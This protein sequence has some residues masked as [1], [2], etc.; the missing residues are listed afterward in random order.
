MQLLY[1][2]QQDIDLEAICLF[3]FVKELLS[4]QLMS[5]LKR[6]Q[7]LTKMHKRLKDL[8]S[9]GSDEKSS[10]DSKKHRHA[11][12]YKVETFMT[13]LRWALHTVQHCSQCIRAVNKNNDTE[14]S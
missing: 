13:N 14:G 8:I 9:G 3:T 12:F 1:G 2:D 7:I 4:F 11:H 10:M 5:F 6:V